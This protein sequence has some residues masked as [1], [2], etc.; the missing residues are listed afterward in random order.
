MKLIN[1]STLYCSI[2]YRNVSV[3]CKKKQ[4]KKKLSNEKDMK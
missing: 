1:N 2:K 4:T 3:V